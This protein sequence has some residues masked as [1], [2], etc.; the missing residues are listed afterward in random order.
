MFEGQIREAANYEK[1]KIWLKTEP[2]L[3]NYNITYK[4]MRDIGINRF[5][6]SVINLLDKTEKSKATTVFSKVGA[7]GLFTIAS[8]SALAVAIFSINE[9]L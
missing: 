4:Q 1:K 2:R 8:I 9:G 6:I 5:S 7:L 3:I